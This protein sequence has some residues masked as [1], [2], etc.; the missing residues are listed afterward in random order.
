MAI[1][2]FTKWVEVEPLAKITEAKVQDFVWKSIICRF[3]LPR[4]LITDNGLQFA[5]ARFAE[6]CED[7]NISHNFTSV[8]HLQAND[9]AE[10]TN[11][12]L[13][14]GIKARI[15]KAKRTWANELYHVLW[16]YRTI[17]RLSTGETPFALT[18]ETEA[19]IPIEL[20]LLL[21]QVVAF[22]EQCNS[23]DLKANLDL[24]EE[25]WETAQVQIAAY[26]QKIARY[27]NSQ[28]KSK[29]FRAEDL[30]LR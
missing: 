13:L 11:R 14:Q 10:V 29:A 24:L 21:A 3:G 27:Y 9:E 1:D 30:V 23:W 20:K 4:T 12:T 5:G 16:A 2:Y 22:D 7:L 17:Q 15:K 6:F 26:K 25:K 8:I 19:V 18:F 28:V